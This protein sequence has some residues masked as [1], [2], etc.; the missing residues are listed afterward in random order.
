VNGKLCLAGADLQVC[1]PAARIKQGKRRPEGLRQPRNTYSSLLLFA[2][3]HSLFTIHYSNLV[4]DAHCIRRRKLEFVF[5][6]EAAT[7]GNPGEKHGAVRAGNPQQVGGAAKNLVAN[8]SSKAHRVVGWRLRIV[9]GSGEIRL[10][11][12]VAGTRSTSVG[13]QPDAFRAK[14]K[15]GRSVGYI[16]ASPGQQSASRPTLL[17]AAA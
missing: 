4:S 2:I 5:A 16:S 1:D 15:G 13:A 6:F 3:H 12:T 14:G 17:D 9:S 10:S 11:E 7:A 8:R